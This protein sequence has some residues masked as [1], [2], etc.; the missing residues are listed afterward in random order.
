MVLN[1]GFL[2]IHDQF[3]L[4]IFSALAVL[5]FLAV[6]G[7]AEVAIKWPNDVMVGAGKICGILIE[8]QLSGNSLTKSVIGI[9]LN[10]NQRGF[11]V[12]HATSLSLVQDQT[13]HLPD[14]LE[15]IL[16]FLEARYLQLRRSDQAGLM[17]DYLHSLFGLNQLRTFRAGGTDF[18]G[19]I[20]GVDPLGR[21]RVMVGPEEKVFAAKE[22]SFV[23]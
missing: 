3:Y 1:T 22:I 16:S 7:C 17:R 11:E 14:E 9:G 10:I 20:S 2:S 6:K 8:N 21:L 13:Y 4:N 12:A 5:D 23:Q 19:L 15:V 18:E